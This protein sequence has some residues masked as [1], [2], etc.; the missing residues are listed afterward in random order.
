MDTLLCE[1][2]MYLL[3]NAQKK[4]LPSQI[5]KLQSDATAEGLF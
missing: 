4:K 1:Q 5:V 3:Y 2:N